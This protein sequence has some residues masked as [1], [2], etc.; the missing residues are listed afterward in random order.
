MCCISKTSSAYWITLQKHFFNHILFFCMHNANDCSL[1]TYIW[2]QGKW[3]Q[4]PR[5]NIDIGIYFVSDDSI[6][7]EDYGFTEV[8][9]GVYNGCKERRLTMKSNKR[10]VMSF[11]LSY[12]PHMKEGYHTEQRTHRLGQIFFEMYIFSSWLCLTA[13]G[14]E[15]YLFHL[16][17]Y[18]IL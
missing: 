13:V 12:W 18:S 16:A 15:T 8:S 3:G 7:C 5:V 1:H 14:R 11:Y 17:I 10:K 9:E 4:G 2:L 6:D